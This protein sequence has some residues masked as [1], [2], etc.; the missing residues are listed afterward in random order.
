M[1][2][3]LIMVIVCDQPYSKELPEFGE[4][5]FPLSDFQKYAIEGI[6]EQKNVLITA[7]TG[8][9]KTLP[10]EFAITHFAKKGKKVI[11][12]SPIKALSNQKFYEFSRKYPEISFGLLTGDI[13]T[14]PTADVLIMTTEIL[15]NYL[16]SKEKSA[17]DFQINIEEELGCVIFDEVH[18]INDEHRG[19]T[20]EQT[21]L[22]LPPKIQMVM[23]SATI[24]N[25]EGFAKWIESRP[26]SQPVYLASTEH[27][28]VPLTHY[29]FFATTETPFKTI[30]DKEIQA[31]IRASTNRPILLRTADG[32]FSDKGYHE[33]KSISEIFN[34][35]YIII[36]R[37]FV[38]NK[39]AEYLKQ[40]EMLPA[41]VFVFSRRSVEQCANDMTTNLLEDDSKIPYIV[42][43]E[44]E[45]IVRKFPNYREYLELPE[46]VN[47]VKL[48]EKGVGIHHSGMLPVLREIVELM[49][50]K[51]YIKILFATESFA[52]GLDCPIKTAVFSSLQKFDGSEKRD[53]MPHEY[54]QMAGRAGRRGIDTI[55]TVIHCNNLFFNPTIMDYKTILCGK[56]QKLVSKF[57]ISYSTVFNLMKMGNTANYHEFIDRSMLNNELSSS[58]KYSEKE[59]EKQFEKHQKKTEEI[60]RN[61]TPIEICNE[62][63]NILNII[64][65]QDHKK[66]KKSKLRLD[67]IKDEYKWVLDD[68]NKIVELNK[69]GEKI[70]DE[71]E[72]M[73]FYNNY[74]KI[75]IGGICDILT[76]SGFIEKSA[77]S[78]SLTIPGIIASN[79]H[80]IHPLI[81]SILFQKMSAVVP[82]TKDIISI[83]SLFCDLRVME[84]YRTLIIDTNPAIYPIIKG[85]Q[86]YCEHFEKVEL[87][88]A[89]D[90]GIRYD[91]LLQYDLLQEIGEW[92]DCTTE[93][94]CKYFIQTRLSDREISIGDFTKAV[95]KIVV[96]TN[97][98]ISVCEMLDKIDLLYALKQ[99]E[100]LIC[101]FVATSQSLYV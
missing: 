87:E 8:S 47:L 86:E 90:T 28:V 43:K 49:I 97:E 82:E 51:K 19:Q 4:F 98:F 50:S 44:C 69:I 95:L 15:M 96:I 42:A 78:F 54:T 67:E 68:V 21:I 10:A 59:L 1:I 70:K 101:K 74:T 73:N 5:P 60:G 92:C 37:K 16:F 14:N 13:K 31:K 62:Y 12:T 94:Q 93:E 52:I 11:Y 63:I 36:K 84:E 33:L 39:L 35:N 6:I 64:H 58:K 45:Q 27:R 89:I 23:L 100:A 3:I 77:D 99:I 18:Y 76:D 48:L 32:K 7:H 46:Y 20:W 88:K 38:L 9:G 26:D 83:F 25:P 17:L 72:K 57:K 41:I 53:L 85:I 79:L 66:A 55:G 61:R 34:K 24:D 30:K 29:G 81:G 75:K 65:Y 80:E 22:M 40:N 71:E 2:I 56:P 91:N